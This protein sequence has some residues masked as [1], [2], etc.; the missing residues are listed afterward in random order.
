[1]ANIWLNRANFAMSHIIFFTTCYFGK[2]LL[3]DKT[4]KPRVTHPTKCRTKHDMAHHMVP[5]RGDRLAL[6]LWFSRARSV[7]TSV[8]TKIAASAPSTLVKDTQPADARQT[9]EYAGLQPRT[10][11]IFVG[12]AVSDN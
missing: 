9:T 5:R 1:M 7:G 12:P 3:T 8:P 2:I 4:R 10:A 6:F 11:S